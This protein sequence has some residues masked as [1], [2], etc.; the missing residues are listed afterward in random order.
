M[1]FGV[2]RVPDG[3]SARWTRIDRT[4][5][6][7]MCVGPVGVDVGPCASQGEIGCNR[8]QDVQ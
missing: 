2:V 7:W 1:Q 5:D 3:L 4:F 6:G 8:L